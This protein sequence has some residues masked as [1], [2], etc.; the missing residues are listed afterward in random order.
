MKQTA[1]LFGTRAQCTGMEIYYD[2]NV[3]DLG[4]HG[5]LTIHPKWSKRTSKPGDVY[6]VIDEGDVDVV[7][8]LLR[9][10][11]DGMVSADPGYYLPRWVYE[12]YRKYQD[13]SH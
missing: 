6:L 10:A 9:D 3:H 5:K 8:D 2:I 4:V 13:A 1:D 11:W 7:P 12:H